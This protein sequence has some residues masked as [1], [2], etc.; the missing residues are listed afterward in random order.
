LLSNQLWVNKIKQANIIPLVIILALLVSTLSSVYYLSTINNQ[1]TVLDN[2]LNLKESLTLYNQNY[3]LIPN[4]GLQ[5]G[6]R[7][8]YAGYVKI[9]LDDVNEHANVTATLQYQFEGGYHTFET[10]GYATF[11]ILPTN[12]SSITLFNNDK[13]SN[14]TIHLRVDYFY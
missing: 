1:L 8:E 12:I 9:Y 11:P 4:H 3:E 7:T 6:I 10:N 5:L 2:R 13:M 14:T